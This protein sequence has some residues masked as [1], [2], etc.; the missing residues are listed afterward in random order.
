MSA[1]ALHT[2]TVDLLTLDEAQRR[3]LVAQLQP[4][5]QRVFVPPEDED[6]TAH[7]IKPGALAARLQVSEG[8]AGAP[9]SYS[10]AYLY[11]HPFQGEPCM[12]LRS[13][14]AV[15]PDHRG[16]T[17]HGAFLAGEM[18]RHIAAWPGRR[19]FA[20]DPIVHPTSFL[21][22]TRFMGHIHPHWGYDTPPELAGFVDGV[23]DAWGLPAVD[24]ADPWVRAVGGRTRETPA[25]RRFWAR[26]PRPEVQ[27]F[28]KLNPDYHEG[29][30]LMVLSVLDAASF[31]AAVGRLGRRQLRRRVDEASARL[32]LLG[33][34]GRVGRDDAVEALAACPLLRGASRT[35]LEALAD[36]ARPRRVPAGWRVIRQGDE[37]DALYV[38]TEGAA[39]VELEEGGGRRPLD[40]LE[41]GAMFGEMGLLLEQPRSATVRAA[42]ALRLLE[43]DRAALTGLMDRDPAMARALWSEVAR[44]CLVSQALAS[45]RLRHLDHHGRR[46]WIGAPEVERLH[47]G[48]RRVQPEDG[49]LL[50]LTGGVELLAGRYG[51]LGPLSLVELE[52]GEQMV[53]R[54]TTRVVRLPPAPVA[55]VG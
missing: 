41:V 42:S 51:R 26:D 37:A 12:V 53:A 45:P 1:E 54:G 15:H 11:E 50:V 29:H 27:F 9:I 31:L 43:I 36:A 17:L 8:P 7:L 14:M 25:E 16:R 48:E 2:R 28:L 32:Q 22:K 52:A 47:D 38:I 6:L 40:Q 34:S 30:G 10:G 55:A 20:L 44:R 13:T 39:S 46:R 49:T 21:L 5:H 23:A 35:S 19:M 33:W 18:L 3:S 24:P 4:L